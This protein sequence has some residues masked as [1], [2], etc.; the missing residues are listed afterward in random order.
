MIGLWWIGAERVESTHHNSQKNI[1]RILKGWRVNEGTPRRVADC[2]S[3]TCVQPVRAELR[4]DF[5]F[6][7][8][9]E[10][11]KLLA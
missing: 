10:E 4:P 11:R 2:A 3:A 6:I 7:E 1:L 8:R 5:F 9:N